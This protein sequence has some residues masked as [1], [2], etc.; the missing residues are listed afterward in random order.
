MRLMLHTVRSAAEPCVVLG[1]FRPKS[2]RTVR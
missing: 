1:A 2:E